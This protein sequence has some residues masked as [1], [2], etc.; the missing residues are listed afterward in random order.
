M[1]L[2]Q[3]Q[4]SWDDERAHQRTRAL[5]ETIRHQVRS[6]IRWLP[7]ILLAAPLLAAAVAAI[8]P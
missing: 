6:D 8:A 7:L 4:S 1:T 2:Y 5:R 3:L